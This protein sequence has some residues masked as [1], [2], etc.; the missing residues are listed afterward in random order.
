[1]ATPMDFNDG[2]GFAQVEVTVERDEDLFLGLLVTREDG[3]EVVD[4]VT[5]D[6]DDIDRFFAEVREAEAK[7]HALAGDRRSQE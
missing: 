6:A 7:W 4:M 2:S 3:E 1:M 5:T